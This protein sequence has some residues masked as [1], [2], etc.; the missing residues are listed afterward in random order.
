MITDGNQF[1]DASH[2]STK[3]K[4]NKMVLG[5][6]VKTFFVYSCSITRRSANKL[7]S[8]DFFEYPLSKYCRQDF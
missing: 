4:E 5:G 6:F 3:A 7:N 1:E 2:L 8:L